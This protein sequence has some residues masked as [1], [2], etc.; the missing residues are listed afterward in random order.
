MAA[1]RNTKKPKRT[2]HIKTSGVRRHRY[3]PVVA[4]IFLILIAIAVFVGYKV[5]KSFDNPVLKKPETVTQDNNN[6]NDNKENQ[7]NAKEEDNKS[8]DDKKEEPTSEPGKSNPQYEG[9]N[10]NNSDT[11]TGV[12][13]Y[14]G[15][16]DGY[17][18]VRVA[19]DQTISSGNCDFALTSASGRAYNFSNSTTSG[20]SSTY[21][22]LNVPFSKLNNESGTWKI[23]AKITST[24]GKTGVISGEGAV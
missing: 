21:C 23:S 20:P 8:S 14:V 11:L 4:I 2:G 3:G 24:S 15:L 16:S 19:I 5:I 6:D 17:F 13:N 9:A 12:I 1:K 7:S 22:G 10:V 18:M